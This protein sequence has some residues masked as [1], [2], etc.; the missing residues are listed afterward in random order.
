[1]AEINTY[2]FVDFEIVDIAQGQVGA[3]EGLSDGQ[4]RGLVEIDGHQFGIRIGDNFKLRIEFVQFGARLADENQRIRAVVDFAGVGGSDRSAV[5]ISGVTFAFDLLC[6]KNGL[7]LFHFF[8]VESAGLVV[9]VNHS[10]LFGG[11]RANLAGKHSGLLR[12]ER[13]LVA[14]GAEV[15]L[16]PAR[17]AHFAGSVLGEEARDQFVVRTSQGIVGQAVQ[18]LGVPEPVPLPVVFDHEGNVAHRFEP[19]DQREVAVSE[20]ERLG[21]QNHRLEPG[22]AQLVDVDARGLRVDSGAEDHLATGVLAHSGRQYV[23][24]NDFIDEIWVNLGFG[25]RFASGGNGQIDS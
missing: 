24:E 1:M 7:Q 17:D 2:Y 16:L 20:F 18:D 3:L 15:V 21:S 13:V 22:C 25:K 11:Q 19:A 23:S 4:C 14:S 10:A 9:A 8:G 5:F 6:H 12:V